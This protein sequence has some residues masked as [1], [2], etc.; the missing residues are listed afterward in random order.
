[1]L[2]I[3]FALLLATLIPG[4]RVHIAAAAGLLAATSAPAYPTDPLRVLEP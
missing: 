3:Y 1:M 2:S 4:L